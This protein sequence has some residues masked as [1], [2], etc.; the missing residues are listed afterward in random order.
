M[1][2]FVTQLKRLSPRGK[3]SK[4]VANFY[5]IFIYLNDFLCLKVREIFELFCVFCVKFIIKYILKKAFC[6]WYLLLKK[7]EK[8][9][10]IE[11]I[12]TQKNIKKERIYI[13]FYRFLK[14]SKTVSSFR[15]FQAQNALSFL[16]LFW[17]KIVF[18]TKYAWYEPFFERINPTNFCSK[19]YKNTPKSNY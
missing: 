9:R 1:T 16:Q 7:C 15:G 14:F 11:C 18:S 5:K 2:H 19:S 3:R 6:H 4:K 12:L 13:I 8:A 17:H 10:S